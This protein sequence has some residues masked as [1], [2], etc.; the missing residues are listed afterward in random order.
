MEIHLQQADR[1]EISALPDRTHLGC[2]DVIIG[3]DMDTRIKTP[4]EKCVVAH[5]WTAE[6]VLGWAKHQD[7]G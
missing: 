7:R 2:G 1:L 4:E 5:K 3:I 6:N